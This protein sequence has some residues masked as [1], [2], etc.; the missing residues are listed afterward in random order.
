MQKSFLNTGEDGPLYR[1]YASRILAAIESGG[2]EPGLVL[3]EG[4]LSAIFGTSRATVRRALNDIADEG[5][6][7]RFEGRG[8]VVAGPGDVPPV[9]RSIS[10][11]EVIGEVAA[12]GR[13]AADTIIAEVEAALLTAIAFGHYRIDERKLAEA[14]NVSRPIAR[15]VL[16]RLREA[17]LVE[18]ELHSPWLAGPVTARAVADDRELRML[19]EPHALKLSAHFLDRSELRQMSQRVA[20]ARHAA[21]KVSRNAVEAIEQDLHIGCL[22]H[23]TNDRV[24]RVMR[25]GR[26]PMIVD[27]LFAD[28]IGIYPDDPAFAEH[29][30]VIDQLLAGEFDAAAA[31]HSAHLRQESKRTLDRLKV[32]SV[33]PEPDVAPYLERIV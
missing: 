24:K 4:R 33:L 12:A 6:I 7:Y 26:L 32:L 30:I 13:P 10:A 19:L 11:E 1:L 21:G 18:K 15:E 27:A 29:A 3:L 20:A 25:T 31:S 5:R 23:Y 17:G 9:R 8:F 2:F 16:W 28:F 14:F 22:R